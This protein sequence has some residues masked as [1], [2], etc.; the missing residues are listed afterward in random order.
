MG[1][2]LI[3]ADRNGVIVDDLRTVRDLPRFMR[4][5]PFLGNLC[6]GTGAFLMLANLV[7]TR[8]P[9]TQD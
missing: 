4:S 2:G 8:H 7:G 1:R 9:P 3:V 5:L 6:V